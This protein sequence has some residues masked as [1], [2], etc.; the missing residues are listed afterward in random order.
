MFRT[1]VVKKIKTHVLCSIT[2]FENR[3]VYEKMWENILHRGRLQMS[4]EAEPSDYLP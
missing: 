1:K 4:V 3:A 2:F